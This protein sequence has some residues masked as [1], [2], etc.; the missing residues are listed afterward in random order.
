MAPP[1]ETSKRSSI[2]LSGNSGPSGTSNSAERVTEV[3]VVLSNPARITLLARCDVWRYF[4]TSSRME[5]PVAAEP[6]ISACADYRS[7]FAR[8]VIIHL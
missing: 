5:Q 4:L 2:F 8:K 6:N 1:G 3:L 7:M